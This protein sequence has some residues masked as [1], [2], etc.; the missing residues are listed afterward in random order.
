MKIQVYSVNTNDHDPKRKDDILTFT[1]WSKFTSPA[2]GARFYKCAPHILFPE[3]DWTIYVD[4][5]ISLNVDPELLVENCVPY[6]FGV[7]E[8]PFRRSVQ[9]EAKVV[10]EVGLDTQENV[11]KILNRYPVAK[12]AQGLAMCG[13]IVRKN[14]DFI[15]AKNALWW[16]EICYSSL[17]D[18][19]SFSLF[20]PFHCFW[21]S[22]DIMSPNKYFTRVY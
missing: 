19:L 18:Q 12:I 10:V 11:D 13:V 16:Q 6:D 9:E 1:D 14:N 21:D 5:N 17:R 15:N 4:G 22:I 3:A 7:F 2:L 8:H 20:F